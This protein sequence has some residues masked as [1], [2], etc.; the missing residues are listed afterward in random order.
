MSNTK[1]F[2]ALLKKMDTETQT[3]GCR[4]ANPDHCAKNLLQNV[5]AFVREDG[6]CLSRPKSWPKQF[7]KL[8]EAEKK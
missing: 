4:H 8:T 1:A 7:K 5:C 2:H 6:I 3:V